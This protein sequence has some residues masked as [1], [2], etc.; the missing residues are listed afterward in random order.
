MIRPIAPWRVLEVTAL[1]DDRLSVRFVDGRTGIVDLS[2][3]IASPKAGVLERLRD[4]TLFDQAHVEVGTV[5]WPGEL[6]LAPVAMHAG[7]QG[8]QGVEDCPVVGRP[9]PMTV[10][11]SG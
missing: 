7:D 1:Q 8:A 3:L 4:R 5:V 9:A 11:T 2:A 6:D 10:R